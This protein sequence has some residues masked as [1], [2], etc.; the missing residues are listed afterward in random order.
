MHKKPQ[1]YFRGLS[2]KELKPIIVNIG[3]DADRGLF[4]VSFDYLQKNKS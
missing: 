4:K 3:L 2:L 1:F